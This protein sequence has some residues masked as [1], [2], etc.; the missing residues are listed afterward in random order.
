M[1]T[2]DDKVVAMSFES[3]KFEKGVNATLQAL[4][5]LK[6]ALEFTGVGKGFDAI[7][8]AAQGIQLGHIG[9]AVDSVK[10]KLSAFRIAAIAIFV[11]VAKQAVAAGARFVKAFT[12]QPLI[13]GFQEYSTN[14][15]AIQTILANTQASGATL[16]DVNAALLDLNKYSDKTIYNFSQMA[17]NIGTFTAAGVDLDTSTQAIKGIANLAAL[18]GSSADQ[19]STAMY[20]LSQAISAGTVHLQDW[21]SVVNAGMGGTVFQRALAETAQAMG[22]LKEG[23]V[24]LV[25]PMKN[26]S[27]AGES[28]R[29]SLAGGGKGGV[30]Q[31]LTS[32]VLTTTLKQFTG[33]LTDAQLAAMG[34]SQQQIKAIQLTAKTAMHAA[35][36]VKTIS[37]VLDVAKETA[38]SGWAQTWQLIFGDFGEAK[39]TFT[40]LSN[41]IN[42]FINANAAARNKVLSDW[43]DLGGRTVLIDSIRIAF[44]N[45]GKILKPIKQAFRDIFPPTTG[46][47]LFRLTLLFQKFAKALEPSPATVENL[48]R[49][50]R[51]LF[52]ILDI[53][54]QLMQGIFSVFAK[55]FQSVGAGNGSVLKITGSLGDFLVVLDESLKKGGT[56]QKFFD[57]LVTV[58]TTLLKPFGLLRNYIA[59]LFSGFSPGGFSVQIDAASKAATVFHNVLVAISK[60]LQG[61]GPAISSAI[62]Q[63]NFEAIL[64][65]I[66][67][68][69]FAA[70]VLMFRNFLGKG[71]FLQQISKGFA[72]GI[73]RNFSSMFGS[74]SGSLKAFQQNIQAKTLKEIA[75]S[76]ALLAGSLVALSFVDPKRLN[77]AIGA[78]TFAFAELLGAM[79]ILDKIIKSPSF[80][81][82]P[83]VTGSMILFAGA[84]DLL[85]ISVI[86]LGKQSWDSLK[87][88]LT[89]VGLLL[90]GISVATLPLSKNSA[91]LIK[92][93]IAM[94]AIA[95]SMKILASAVKSF[96]AMNLE[97]LGKGLAAV[98]VGLATFVLALKYMPPTSVLQ[99]A[100][101]I[102]VAAALKILAKVTQEFGN[103][104]WKVMAKGMAGIGISLVV[105]AGA[106]KLMPADT[107][108]IAGGLFV[109]AKALQ[110]IAKAVGTMG[111]M[112]ITEIA[113]GLGTLAISLEL[114]SGALYLMSGSLA[115]AV[116]LGVAA[117]GI[118]LLAPALVMLGRQSWPQIVKGLV[119]LAAAIGILALASVALSEAVPAMLGL[120]AALLLIGGG[121]ALAGAGVFLV[122]A[123]LA[124]I[125]VAGPTA[126]GILIKA[127][128]ELA[129]AVPKMIKNL[130]L[131]LLQIVD[132]LSKSAPKFVAAI[133]KI[134][135]MLLDAIIKSA[136]KMRKAFDALINAALGVLHD[137]QA[138]LI[139]AG[140]SLIIA[141]LKGIAQNIQKIE[142][143][144]GTVVTNFIKGIGSF[145]NRVVTAGVNMVIA[146][147]NGI[148]KNVVRLANAGA[149]VVINFINGIADVIKNREP[150]LIAAGANLSTA[151]IQ[152]MLK[153][154]ID[155]APKL[156]NKASEIGHKV[157]GFLGKA[158]H[159][160]SPSKAT[161][162][163]GGFMMQGLAIGLS[164]TREV[165]KAAT[166]SGQSVIDA[167]NTLFQITSPSKVTEQIGRYVGQGFAKGLMGSQQDIK[168]AFTEL[169]NKLLDQM[170]IAGDSIKS[171]NEKLAE[172]EKH[173]KKN[174]EEIA[175]MNVA[176][177]EQKRILG[178]VTAAHTEL[179]KGLD[180]QKGILLNTSKAYD[181]AI[182]KLKFYRDQLAQAKQD[183]A[184]LK[185]QYIDQ[186]AQ[187]P[188]ITLTDAE[189][190]PI[191]DQLGPYEQGITDS[192]AATNK[193]HDTLEKLKG[194]G[195]DEETLKKLAAMGP[196]AQHF[197]DQ[198]VEGGPDAVKKLN[199]LDAKLN[200]AAEGIAT[201]LSNWFK[202]AA[203]DSAQGFVDEWEKKS[204]DLYKVMRKIARGM[205]KAIRDELG[206]KSPSKVFAEIGGYMME[207]MA[208]GIVGSTKTV[209]DSLTDAAG[210]AIDQMKTTFGNLSDIG[211][212]VNPVITPILDLSQ[213]QRSS[214]TLA[215]LLRATPIEATATYGQA[216][217][218]S[219]DQVAVEDAATAVGGTSIKFEQNN[220]SPEALSAIEIYRQTRNLM[221]QARSAIA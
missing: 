62:Q 177:R 58:I 209:T 172:L 155:W 52:A 159:L 208:E 16:K 175:K 163:M 114:L 96:G 13:A 64:A 55:V 166:V 138:K 168:N 130:V 187:T 104:P 57:G 36:E 92:S 69:L 144:A 56:L 118:M 78:M 148:E 108:L 89:G 80:L 160:G 42:G 126:V 124:A 139:Q 49:T 109:V 29:Q 115:G 35:T 99:G 48:R 214:S 46:K 83:I 25:G 12:L 43:K 153:G 142:S 152:G 15:N 116:A 102:A 38:G 191:A 93:S 73:A 9:N 111:G 45:V 14:L 162:E 181:V 203:V 105:I 61:M 72:G 167:F 8:K 67:T 157:I 91:G 3:D 194:M 178:E 127:M 179:I 7:Q 122:G 145:V 216:A 171:M 51:G 18:S 39:R 90:T 113:K 23:S 185:A 132:G 59:N 188:D 210:E 220:Y 32:K 41:A 129:I 22:T 33:D 5:K 110:G 21:N 120:G 165:E 81:K 74:L 198:L 26:V 154:F 103:I 204:G 17:R 156:Y 173:P 161:I 121:L 174:A 136:P 66:R 75:I 97:T 170:R 192:T 184:D 199:A 40:A 86:A 183:L 6:K 24:K 125:A 31:W 169:N 193:F 85:S 19:A 107:L 217:S 133:V 218:I 87:K 79:A 34:F 134:L 128:E 180:K 44:Q 71:S 101:L 215:A 30:P 147:L 10:E 37:Q 28:F 219:S 164:D 143:A 190:N 135:G 68:G 76:I 53:G 77:S 205:V 60:L 119:S 212:D 176:L 100:A 1:A 63:M 206:I 70:L 95:V 50:F 4:E 146:V 150:E 88:G 182:A 186:F 140:L 20:Q 11:D 197:A 189:G 94:N 54:K 65:V 213:V 106:M 131:G 82:L 137:E 84:I 141:L 123:G 112:S 2:V 47:D 117:A 196:A 200:K 149:T 27:I 202:K 211:V 158:V 207:G 201:D 221:S 98:G 195:L 151:I